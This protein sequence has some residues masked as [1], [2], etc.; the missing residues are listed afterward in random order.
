MISIEA[1]VRP[2]RIHSV[3]EALRAAGCQGFYY[4]NVTGEGR[5]RGV[6]VFVGRGGAMASRSSVPKTLIRTVVPD[7]MQERVI[8]AILESARGPGEG[9]I[10]DGKIFISRVEEVVR[11]RTGE[12]AEK[13]L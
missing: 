12:R 13:A 3:T 8:E 11:V 4:V 7:E 1:I 10:G 9:E 6:E 5:Q 2:E